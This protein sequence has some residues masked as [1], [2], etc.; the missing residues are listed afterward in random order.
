MPLMRVGMDVLHIY[1]NIIPKYHPNQI[2]LTGTSRVDLGSP[3]IK[4]Q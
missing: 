2:F 4:L 3:C 1:D